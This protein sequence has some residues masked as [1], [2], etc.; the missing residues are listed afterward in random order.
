M[1]LDC[2]MWQILW[3]VWIYLANKLSLKPLTDNYRIS[4]ESN[5][6]I[7]RLNKL[8]CLKNFFG[9]TVVLCQDMPIKMHPSY[10]TPSPWSGSS[11]RTARYFEFSELKH[12][13]MDGQ[14]YSQI[15]NWVYF[16]TCKAKSEIYQNSIGKTDLN[17]KLD[18]LRYFLRQYNEKK[19]LFFLRKQLT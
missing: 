11:L 9:G 14:V 1:G 15:N 19:T 2:S 4:N 7:C 17:K 3:W 16:R 8:N 5:T 10:D 13:N 18:L 12:N 6:V